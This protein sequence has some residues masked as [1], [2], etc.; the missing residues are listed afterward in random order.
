[1]FRG[2]SNWYTPIFIEGCKGCKKDPKKTYAKQTDK[3]PG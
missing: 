3:N 1:M 2:V